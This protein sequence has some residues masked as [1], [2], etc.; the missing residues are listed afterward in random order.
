M[1]TTELLK[2]GEEPDI[3]RTKPKNFKMVNKASVN[4]FGHAAWRLADNKPENRI[5]VGKSEFF[6]AINNTGE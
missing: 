3:I 1:N 5:L 4:K 2:F 6:N